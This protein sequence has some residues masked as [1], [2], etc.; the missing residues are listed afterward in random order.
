MAINLFS[1]HGSNKAYGV[2]VFELNVE[3]I[4]PKVSDFRG[5]TQLFS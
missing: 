4:P 5:Y 3:C 1:V 2:G